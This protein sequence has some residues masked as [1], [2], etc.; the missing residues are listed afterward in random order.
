M[1]DKRFAEVAPSLPLSKTFYYRVPGRFKDSIE[2]GKRVLVPLGKRNL[3]GYVL[4]FPKESDIDDIKDIL[5][6]LDDI[7][8]FGKDELDLFHWISKYYFSPIGEVMKTAL[9]KGINIETLQTL[10]IT[11]KGKNL[12]SL[13]NSVYPFHPAKEI[14]S[15]KAYRI[16]KEIPEKKGVTTSHLKKK[17]SYGNLHNALLRL[18][19]EGLIHIDIK[20]K[21]KRVG[22]KTE[23]FIK[24]EENR[25]SK[26]EL[27]LALAH[28]ENKAPKQT[29]I[30]KFIRKNNRVSFQTLKEEF[31]NP[32]ISIRKLQEKGFVSVQSEEVYRNPLYY[33]SYGQ[34][35][36]PK[37]TDKQREVL[38]RIVQGIKSCRFSPYLLFGVTGS[39][40]TEIYMRSV[41]EVLDSGK[42][43]IV[44][45]PEISLTS[46]LVSRFRTRFGNTIA[47]L[48]S[49]LSEG[50]RYDEWRRIKK[51]EVKIAIG[52][53]SA[54]FAPFENLGI[55]IVDEE[56]DASYK[57]EEKLQ[58]SARDMAIVR[59][60]K[61]SA[62]VVLGSAT[63]SLESY[64]NSQIGKLSLL[65]LPNRVENRPLPRVE[66]V[67]MREEA[68]ENSSHNPIFSN[69]LKEA[70]K[71][72]LNR[73]EQIL[74]FLNRRGFATFVIC[75][76]CGFI[77]KCPNCS[78][79]LVHHLKGNTIHCHYCDYS[80]QI[81][82]LCLECKKATVQTF[83]LGTE[84]IEEEVKRLFPNARVARMDRDTITRKESHYKLLKSVEDGETDVLV[85]TQMIAK[86]HDLPNV[87]L[88][89]VTSADTSLGFPDFRASERTFQLLTQ[90]AGRAGRGKLKGRVIVQ[91]YN[92]E[93][94]SIQQARFHDFVNF[95]K[96]EINFRKALNYPPFCRLINFR[97]MGSSKIDTAKYADDLGKLSRDFLLND[98]NYQKSIEILG[99]VVSPIERLKGKYRWQI[100]IKGQKPNLLHCFAG[101]V[102]KRAASRIKGKGVTLSVDA[103]PISM[104]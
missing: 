63:P 97:I 42:E 13:S 85:G 20:P 90:V 88:V 101:Q 57:Q 24:Y 8:L 102:L 51:R 12:L 14:I 10:S 67:D 11:E 98:R 71:E 60:K 89:G 80:T 70:M 86:G 28:L 61:A 17:L 92:P 94:Y 75:E 48:H 37:L 103:D 2:I 35:S 47:L 93:H 30:L 95:Y 9:P 52:V 3:T 16:L 45:V 81:P 66:V 29:R 49:R 34:D 46:Q 91:T 64:Y 82:K 56:H 77:I 33:E 69:R 104:L 44:L 62:T 55:I 38:N 6:V 40:K 72:T 22:R 99:P 74:L 68:K 1:K 32:Y 53:R 27:T 76:K 79:S 100:L 39:G 50:E 96:Q 19:D 59:G 41:E 23:S 26:E 31:D 83:G 4:G 15:N 58:Y 18:R 73:K 84:R 25:L 43:A 21:Q 54:I 87:T 5:D 65:S 36:P 78:V 7:P